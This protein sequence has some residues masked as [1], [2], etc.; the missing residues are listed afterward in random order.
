MAF[1]AWDFI[2]GRV[3]IAFWANPIFNWVRLNSFFI[4]NNDIGQTLV[5][6]DYEI[7]SIRINEVIF[8]LRALIREHIRCTITKSTIKS[9]H[10]EVVSFRSTT[11]DTLRN[12]CILGWIWAFCGRL[13]RVISNC[14]CQSIVVISN[15]CCVCGQQFFT[16]PIHINW[17]IFLTLSASYVEG[18]VIRALI[19][20]WFRNFPVIRW[21]WASYA[22]CTIEKWGFFRAESQWWSMQRQ[23]S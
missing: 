10:I 4:L 13:S 18:C 7:W 2:F 6:W 14:W 21:P 16:I 19:T 8:P 9:L 1:S 12:C 23:F 22:N 17:W 11:G 15:W 20:L 3:R 5:C